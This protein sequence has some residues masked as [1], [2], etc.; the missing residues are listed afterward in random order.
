MTEENFVGGSG[1]TLAYYINACVLAENLRGVTLTLLFTYVTGVKIV[2][3][4]YYCQA[5]HNK[6]E[7]SSYVHS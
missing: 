3:A 4:I 7:T 6:H 2:I 1:G 5:I